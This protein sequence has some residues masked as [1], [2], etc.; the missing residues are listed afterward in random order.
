MLYF[1]L[2]SVDSW[3]HIII[4]RKVK[5]CRDIVLIFLQKHYEL[6]QEFSNCCPQK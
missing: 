3:Q 6:L 4:T 1:D 5:T 2:T